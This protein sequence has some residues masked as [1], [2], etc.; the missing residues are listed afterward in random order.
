MYGD[1]AGYYDVIHAGR[2]R[3]ADVEATMV[4]AELRRRVP[5]LRTV[6][7]VG[8]GT[9]AHL[10]GFVAAG[11]EVTGVDPSPQMLAFAARRAPGVEL[12]EGALPEL[13]LGPDRR[14]DAI[15]SLF[16]VIGYLVEDGALAR[17]V[18]AL[19]RHLAPGGCLL[20]EG[21][22]EPEFWLDT[23]RF[24]AESVSTPDLAVARTVR[25]ERDGNLTSLH[26]RY[27]AATAEGMATVDEHH[28][29]RLADPVEHEAAFLAA[30]LTFERLPHMLHP[31]RAVCV[32]VRT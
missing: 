31:G 9:G 17:G 16:S 8:C 20:V 7:D 4:V 23:L 10:P 13:D 1:A 25:N 2:Q 29:L 24:G 22:L 5:G 3:D 26:M 21:W 11:L 14:F 32:G 30:G 15:V 6:L 12:V 27:V 19:A 18:A 28:V